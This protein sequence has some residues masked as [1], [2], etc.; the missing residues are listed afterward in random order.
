MT[1][2]DIDDIPAK[3]FE[4]DGGG[5]VQLRTITAQEFKDIQRRTVK[6]KDIYRKVDGTPARFE[7]TEIDQ[8]LQNE[9]YWDASIVS[10]EGLQDRNGAEIPCTRENKVLLMTRS[11]KF[12]EFVVESLQKLNEDEAARREAEAKN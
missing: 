4:M 8:D 3:W 6:I 12:L 11:K 10:W 9:M 2:I 7:K 5:R 1:I